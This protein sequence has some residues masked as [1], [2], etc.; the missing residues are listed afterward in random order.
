V[1]PLT[2]RRLLGIYLDDHA[3]LLVGGYELVRRAVRGAS[4]PELR[5]LLEALLPE[6]RDDREAV[7]RIAASVG[8]RPSRL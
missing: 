5:R 1:A 6:L 8:H 4:E 7:D 3:A 2:G